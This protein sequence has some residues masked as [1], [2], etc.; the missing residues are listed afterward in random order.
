M[1]EFIICDLSEEEEKILEDNGVDFGIESLDSRDIHVE[2]SRRRFEEIL[3]LINRTSS[4]PNKWSSH[5]LKGKKG[6]R[7]HGNGQHRK[8]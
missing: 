4:Y 7:Q 2:C 3:V 6:G 8:G 5:Q 1:S